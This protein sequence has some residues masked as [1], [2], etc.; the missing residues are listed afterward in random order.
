[1]ATIKDT[2]IKIM[3]DNLRTVYLRE[4]GTEYPADGVEIVGFDDAFNKI[5]EF[6]KQLGMFR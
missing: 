4:D 2:I 1:M 6:M 5:F 3:Q